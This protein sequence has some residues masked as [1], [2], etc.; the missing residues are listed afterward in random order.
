MFCWLVF[1]PAKKG[2]ARC[3]SDGGCKLK[4]A[5]WFE[6]KRRGDECAGPGVS[7]M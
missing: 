1:G 3:A 2:E 5:I 6:S 4:L 7:K